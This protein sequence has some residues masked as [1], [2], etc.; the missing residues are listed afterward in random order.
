MARSDIA[1]F[2]REATMSSSGY[3]LNEKNGFYVGDIK[4]LH[5]DILNGNETSYL[6]EGKVG[7]TGEWQQIQGDSLTNRHFK[8]A[9]I[10]SYEYI[11]LKLYDVAHN[12]DVVIFG[13]TDNPILKELTVKEEQSVLERNVEI[14]CLL[15]EIKEELQK[16]NIFLSEILGEEL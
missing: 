4:T 14:V 3:F 7:R 12:V 8:N 1:P 11:R 16:N 9:D 10:S 15:T 2:R 6:L 5:M 13:Y